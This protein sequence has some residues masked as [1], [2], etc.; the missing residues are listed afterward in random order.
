VSWLSKW[1]GRGA[2]SPKGPAEHA[3]IVHFNYGSTDLSRLFQPEARLQSAIAA[4]KVGEFDGNEIASDG[5]DGYLYMYG[6]NAD[7]LFHAIRPLLEAVPFMKGA[8]VRK[9][10]GPPEEG[11]REVEVTLGS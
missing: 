4:A 8:T 7:R 10:Y 5:S 6:P 9:R 1:F 11:T 2:P 3:V